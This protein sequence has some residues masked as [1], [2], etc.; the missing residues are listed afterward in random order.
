LHSPDDFVVSSAA[1]EVPGELEAD[2]VFGGIM[3]L[4]EQGFGSNQEAGRADA[5]LQGSAF[6]EALLQ[7]MQVALLGEALD[8]LELCAFSF[9]GQDDAAIDRQAVHQ[10]GAGA[11]VA[12]V[13]ALFGT[14]QPQIFSEHFQKALPRFAKELGCFAV[15]SGGDV[16][17]F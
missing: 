4:I 11:A 5:A 3:S 17:F 10:H 1:A 8:R 13:A 16:E 12:V 14:R 2:F 7:W 9:G 6:E 15:D